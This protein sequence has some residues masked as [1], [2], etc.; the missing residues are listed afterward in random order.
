MQNDSNKSEGQERLLGHEPESGEEGGSP[1]AAEQE[2]KRLEEAARR[3]HLGLDRPR[4]VRLDTG[5]RMSIPETAGPAFGLKVGAASD[6]A[7]VPVSMAGK[8]EGTDAPIWRIELHGL[9][10]DA[11]LSGYDIA[12]DAVIGRGTPGDDMVDMDL[13]QCK[14]YV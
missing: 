5:I 1:G 14:T 12:S 10:P 7:L 8:L 3:R 11:A 4:T 9:G 13:T 6:Y 2:R